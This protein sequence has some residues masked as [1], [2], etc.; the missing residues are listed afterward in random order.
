M[1]QR[2]S[3]TAFIVPENA[4]VCC[5]K[6]L[7]A[8]ARRESR[9]GTLSI[10]RPKRPAGRDRCSRIA[11]GA[12][13]QGTSYEGNCAQVGYW[14]VSLNDQPVFGT[15]FADDRLGRESNTGNRL[16]LIACR[17]NWPV[18]VQPRPLVRGP[19]MSERVLVVDD[20]HD[21]ADCLARL[22]NG[23]GDEAK[24]VYDG[25]AAIKQAAEFHP[26]MVLLDIGMPGLDGYETL[27]RIRQQQQSK[28]MIF[29]ALTAW[30]R[31]EDKRHA[32]ECGFDLHVAKP[33]TTDKLEE[34]LAL[35]DPEARAVLDFAN[36]RADVEY[37]PDET[38]ST[39][40]RVA[41]AP[42]L[43]RR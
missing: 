1:A 18:K 41:M 3:R 21:A 7:S 6:K 12:L 14:L 28:E 39:T 23:F 24:A 2:A 20:N 29:V 42:S 15:R 36:V 38:V 31:D 26:D 43:R 34:L 17:S 19:T 37:R 30:S 4:N 22:I 33:M 35:L 25:N 8:T 9:D 32:Y 27:T 11:S 16:Y 13:Q 10:Q 40:R 5:L